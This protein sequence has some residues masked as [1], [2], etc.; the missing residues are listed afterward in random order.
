M[1][2]HISTIRTDAFAMLRYHIIVLVTDGIA[3]VDWQNTTFALCDVINIAPVCTTAF[4]NECIDIKLSTMLPIKLRSDVIKTRTGGE[5]NLKAVR[6]Q[7]SL[8][9]EDIDCT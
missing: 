7:A 6:R 5:I 3:T 2:Y 4:I 9:R 1:I 8:E